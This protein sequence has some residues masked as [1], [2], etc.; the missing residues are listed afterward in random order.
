MQAAGFISSSEFSTLC[1]QFRNEAAEQRQLEQQDSKL[2][3]QG[4]E[5]KEDWEPGREPGLQST[6]LDEVGMESRMESGMEAC[7]EKEG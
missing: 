7:E 3:D 5:L 1:D 4:L 6:K 2:H